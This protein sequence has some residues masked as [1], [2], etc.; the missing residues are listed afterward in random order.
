[1]TSELE[2]YG[3]R[4]DRLA[5]MEGKSALSLLGYTAIYLTAERDELH[6]QLKAKS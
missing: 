3:I 1:M 2:R 6:K 4:V 5:A